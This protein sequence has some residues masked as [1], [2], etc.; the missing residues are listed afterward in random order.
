[1]ENPDVELGK[2]GSG[3]AREFILDDKELKYA[4][5]VFG[6]IIASAIV[7]SQFVR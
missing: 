6:L 2:V 3:K 7:A 4:L 5:V 1:M